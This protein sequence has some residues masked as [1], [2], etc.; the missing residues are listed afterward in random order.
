M[1]WGC[2]DSRGSRWA[3]RSQSVRTAKDPGEAWGGLED[4]GEIRSRAAR[5]CYCER[6]GGD[7]LETLL[8]T[9]KYYH[10]QLAYPLKRGSLPSCED[11][12]FSRCAYTF[13]RVWNQSQ[14]ESKNE[15]NKPA[16]GVIGRQDLRPV[17]VEQSFSKSGLLVVPNPTR[18]VTQRIT[19]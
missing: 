8:F 6:L 10:T 1:V 3:G 7:R 4:G 14:Q 11:T 12:Y 19:F 5:V 16:D 15:A 18:K 17:P 9:E 2:Q 13:I